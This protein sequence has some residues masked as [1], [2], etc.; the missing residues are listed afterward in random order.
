MRSTRHN[1][2]IFIL[3]VGRAHVAARALNTHSTARAASKT[4]SLDALGSWGAVVLIPGK[5][6][7]TFDSVH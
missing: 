1:L 7:L 3:F 5:I 4:D 2:L 6:T